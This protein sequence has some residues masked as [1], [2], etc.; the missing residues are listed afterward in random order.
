[1]RRRLLFDN[2]KTQFSPRTPY[3]DLCPWHLMVLIGQR[4]INS[5]DDNSGVELI[6]MAVPSHVALVREAKS[7]QT[8][9]IRADP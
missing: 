4:G 8:H 2:D 1:M 7:N 6:A 3:D 5:P 9:S